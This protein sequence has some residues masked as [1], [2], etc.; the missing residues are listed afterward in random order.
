VEGRE[1]MWWV[2]KRSSKIARSLLIYLRQCATTASRNPSFFS[3]RW[4]AD[5]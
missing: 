1:D 2:A 5:V 4:P 3:L